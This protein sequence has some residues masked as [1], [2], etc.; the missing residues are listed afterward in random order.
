MTLEEYLRAEQEGTPAKIDFRLRF[1]E[2]GGVI[3]FYI[4]PMR[5]DGRTADFELRGNE[6]KTLHV[7]GEPVNEED[8]Q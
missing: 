6:L 1:C 5:F 8:F 2:V 7:T 3:K 4:H